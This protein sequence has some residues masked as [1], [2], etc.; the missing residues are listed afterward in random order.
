MPAGLQ[1]Q[2]LLH[3]PEALAGLMERGGPMLRHPCAVGRDLQQFLF[4]GRIRAGSRLLLRQL[5]IPAG[6]PDHGLA[7]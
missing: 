7:A 6:I 1:L 4:S 3:E 2:E 5:R